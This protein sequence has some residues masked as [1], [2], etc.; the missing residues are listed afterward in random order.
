M[1]D[2]IFPILG[3]ED[4]PMVGRQA[5]A[6]RIWR[7]LTKSSPSNL[8]VVG[9]KYIGKTVLLKSLV[10]QARKPG[11]PYSMVVYWQLGYTPPQS[12]VEFIEQLCDL[13]YSEMGAD[14]AN[15][16]EH[17]AELEGEKSFAVLKEVMDLLQLEERSV[18]MVW[19]GFDKPLS[20]GL[21]S[22]FL[23]GQLRELFYAKRH[24]V[25]TA[26][27]ATQ[28]ELARDI[29]VEDSP[30]W[31]MFDVNP[32]RVGP[33]DSDDCTAA[34]K[35]AE[36]TATPGGQKELRNWTGGQ[37]VLLLSFLNALAK[38]RA[39]ELDNRHVN[40]AAS[41][42]AMDLA[43]FL[44]KLWNSCSA[45]EK[46]AFQ[47]LVKHGAIDKDKF[48]KDEIRYLLANG[49]ALR[50]GTTIKP[51]CRMFA[52]HVQGT[53][54]DTG[55]LE[56]LFGSWQNYRHEIRSVLEMRIKQIGTVNARLHRLVSHCL[57]DIP[58]HPDDC[59]NNLT[60]I[61]DVALEAV[62]KH[63]F[64]SPNKVP[65]EVISYW[66]KYPRDSDNLIKPMMDA[67]DWSLPRDRFKQL[68]L[69]QR[70]TGSKVNFDSKAKSVSKDTYVLLN[71][72]HQFRNRTEHADGQSIHEGVAVSALLLCIELLSCLKRELE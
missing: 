43:D 32:I 27:R 26:T 70:L 45:T 41:Q 60:R 58:E 13:L 63:E 14:A 9:P 28:T 54:P 22:G 72:I 51:A 19:D 31:N 3:T 34:L 12:D 53:K 25:V 7:D 46:N 48:G 65:K 52:E 47:M 62:W 24:R 8:S 35:I 16:K 11:S 68:A 67:D 5:L 56:R 61:E 10:K 64:G 20:Q 4:V 18:L 59:L 2:P 15:F 42:V 55:T 69:L 39:G 1:T 6:T 23:F 36:L 71:A 57:D 29:H 17:R 40:E 66:T 21:L 44:D 33:F 50:D 37:P 38:S 49:F 30:F